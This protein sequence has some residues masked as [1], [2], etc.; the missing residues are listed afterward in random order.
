[1]CA[2]AEPKEQQRDPLT[3][4]M[5]AALGWFFKLF[6]QAFDVVTSGYAW[7]VGW[8]LRLSVV[9]WWCMAVYCF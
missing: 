2:A 1:V 8:L 5:N 3:L 6:N 7:T 9:G 4:V